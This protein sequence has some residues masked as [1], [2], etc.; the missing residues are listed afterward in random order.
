M[1]ADF[2]VPGLASDHDLEDVLA[3][4]RQCPYLVVAGDDDVWSRGAT[5]IQEA[6]RGR[7]LTNV[8]VHARPGEH[9]FPSHD[10]EFVYASLAANL[11]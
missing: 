6:A 5:D 7:G 2:V 8:S 11:G 1:L 3:L 9:A 10:R 4:V